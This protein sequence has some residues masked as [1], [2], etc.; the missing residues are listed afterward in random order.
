MAAKKKPIDFEKSLQDLE[1]LVTAME[2]GDMT[3]E[4][5]LKAFETGIQ[6][7]RECQTRLAEAEQ[8]VQLLTE[9]QGE[10]Q[11]TPFDTDLS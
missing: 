4:E 9:Q 11:A 3:L 2:K 6:L 1:N 7:T 8:K 10:L 5:S